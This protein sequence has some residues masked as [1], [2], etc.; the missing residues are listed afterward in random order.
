MRYLHFLL[1]PGHSGSIFGHYLTPGK[2][3]PQI[4][5]G[6][7]EGE[8]NREL[9]KE[10]IRNVDLRSDLP[11]IQVDNLVPGPC[12][13]PLS[14]RVKT[15]NQV[16]KYHNV[17][18]L[19]V[20]V[21]AH[22]NGRSGWT[23]ADGYTLFYSNKNA[24]KTRSMALADTLD[25][26]LDLDAGSLGIRRRGVKKKPFYMLKNPKAPSVLLEAGFMTNLEDVAH[27]Q[28]NLRQLAA[29][30]VTSLVTFSKLEF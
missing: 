14:T 13:V 25:R 10:I 6:I 5:P 9:V 29:A 23:D 20:H 11:A 26:C 22:G 7:Y 27:L 16:A 4:P 15:V 8:Y 17:V 12:R 3:S 18:L 1:S 2:R 24:F 19:D 30:I 28:E 21:N